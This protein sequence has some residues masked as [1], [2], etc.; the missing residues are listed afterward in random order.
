MLLECLLSRLPK[1]HKPPLADCTFTS[2][3]EPE[4]RNHRS[5]THCGLENKM[6]LG[7]GNEPLPQIQCACGTCYSDGDVPLSL[8]CSE[9]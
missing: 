2:E 7:I 5:A 3:M 4:E 1:S 8:G 6:E 9:I